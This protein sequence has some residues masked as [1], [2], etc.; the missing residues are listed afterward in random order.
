MA[1]SPSLELRRPRAAPGTVMRLLQTFAALSFASYFFFWLIGLGLVVA[2]V[3]IGVISKTAAMVGVGAYL[4]SVAVYTP[5]FGRGWPFHW[6][7]YSHFVDWVLGYYDST[8][9]REGPP[10]DPAGRYLFAMVPHGVFGVCR[11][12]SG[13]TL[14]RSLFPGIDARWGSF[15]G[16]FRLPGVRE[17]SLS[18]GCL[19]AG[20]PTLTRAIQRG[21]NIMLLP[22][23][24]KELLLTD[25][26]STTTQLVLL[27]RTGF[28]RLAIE[29]GLDLVPG[30]CF[31]EKWVHDL[32]LLPAPLRR[33]LYRRF[34]LAGALLIGRWGTFLGK[35][36]SA[37][38]K[39]LSLGYVWGAPIRVTR[40]AEPTAA[41]IAE[42]HAAYVGEVRR[43]FDTYKSRFGYAEGE[44]LELV[45]AK[46]A[47]AA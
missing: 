6:F 16:A 3:V 44:T 45:S 46:S 38:G 40:Q 24:S 23:G 41:Y 47:K 20:R 19:D 29:H 32:V 8:C 30:F 35:V 43:I 7:L 11:A 17:F 26:T 13:G 5:Q 4:C 27:D 22:G 14:W 1:T 34:R 42:V 28:V 18:C 33:Q 2:L 21:E 31:G 9:I 36:A 12:F 39:P 25:G 15:G 10:L 37:D